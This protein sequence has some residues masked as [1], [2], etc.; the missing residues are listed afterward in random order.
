MQRQTS[1]KLDGKPNVFLKIDL[2]FLF[3]HLSGAISPQY[4]TYFNYF[5]AV[6]SSSN[7]LCIELLGEK[8]LSIIST[9]K[10]A[11]V[12]VLPGLVWFHVLH[13][14]PSELVQILEEACDL[15][16]VWGGFQTEFWL[17]E[18]KH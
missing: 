17:N 14:K 5:T 16:G 4:T 11:V 7:P 18:Q 15:F 1:I 8:K 13:N 2:L 12:S 9:Q 3:Q 6:S 10:M